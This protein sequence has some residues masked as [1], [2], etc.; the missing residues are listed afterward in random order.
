MKTK[1]VTEIRKTGPQYRH[2]TVERA[3]LNEEARTVELAFSS[4]EPYERYWGT[5]ILDHAPS[6]VRLGRLK[7]GG[8]LLLDHDP[9]RH[10]GVV[11]RVAIG[12]DRLGRAVVRFGRNAEADA[13]W[14]D[15]Q[16]GIRRHVSVGY[17]IHKMVMTEEKD[18]HETYRV[19]DWEPLEVSLVA[20]PADPTVGV[21]RSAEPEVSTIVVR[22][23]EDQEPQ[24][25]KM[26]VTMTEETKQQP[27]PAE[28]E[29]ARSS[30]ITKLGELYSKYISDKDVG[31]AIRNG[32][33][34]EQ[35]KDTVM[36]KMESRHTDTSEMHVGM[37]PKEAQR[38]SFGRAIVAQMSGDWSKAGLERE[39]SNALAKLMGRSPEGFFV[40]FEALNKRDF[41]VGTTSEAGYLVETGLRADLFTDA[42]REAMVMSRLGVRFLTGLSGNVD[43]P[44]K[45]TV[46]SLGMLTEIGSASETA[47]ATAKLALS[48][49]RIGAY[50][51]VSKQALIQS[52]LALE[53]M[54][55]DDLLTG[56]A[57]LLEYQMIN[58]NG[59]APNLGGIRNTSGIGTVVGGTAGAT[60]AWSHV[61]GLESSVA[62]ANAEPDRLAGY[63]V[64][65][66]TRGK[67][68][69]VQRG[70][71]LS[72]IWGDGDAPLNGY[73]AFVTNNLPSNLTKG[74]STTVCS[75]ALFSSDWS[76][77]VIGLF[78][79]P[80]VTVDPFTLAATGQVRITLNQFA[81]GGVRQPAAFAKMDDI[82]TA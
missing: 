71:N 64:N 7:N 25:T 10:I 24:P 52:A 33:S 4:E 32:H 30:E 45:A 46:G 82:L 42:F 37:T 51:E 50:T 75:A 2:L 55:R 53:G 59:T 73:R 12:D 29:R 16:D 62:N 21:G 78:G 40:P 68:K 38:Y 28:L 1:E 69:Q 3:A 80:D 44:R 11:D 60:I 39:A 22:Q 34:V 27:T 81:D 9:R 58:G 47:P 15:V 77:A 72:F 65:T 23:V 76:M 17:V 19:D 74:S 41:N 54:I 57:V 13:A 18:G 66:A 20:I 48:P 14:K 79:A 5:E 35:F 67:A 43:I 31:N 6:S 49:K 70:T 36:A 26:R 8:A 56:A 61:V 63:L